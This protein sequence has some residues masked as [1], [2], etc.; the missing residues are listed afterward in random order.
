MLEDKEILA[1]PWSHLEIQINIMFLV[2][3]QLMLFQMAVTD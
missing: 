1:Q 2:L 3:D